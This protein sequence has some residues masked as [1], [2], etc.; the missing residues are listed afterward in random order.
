MHRPGNA[1]DC[2]TPPGVFQGSTSYTGTKPG[3]RVTYKC[4]KGTYIVGSASATCTGH[5]SWS[6]ETPECRVEYLTKY[7][8]SFKNGDKGYKLR[9][10]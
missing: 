5:G 1:V 4:M 10:G 7:D 8:N 2:G 9:S 6:N 3:S